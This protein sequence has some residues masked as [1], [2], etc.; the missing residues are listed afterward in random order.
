MNNVCLWS[1]IWLQFYSSF[2]YF[3]C[4]F[5]VYCILEQAE[6]VWSYFGNDF[7]LCYLTLFFTVSNKS[8]KLFDL[9]FKVF[10]TFFIRLMFRNAYCFCQQYFLQYEF[11]VKTRKKCK[12]NTVY[13]PYSM[14]QCD[15]M[16]ITY[17]ILI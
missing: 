15:F 1:F 9:L 4:L 8:F 10:H 16:I 14:L 12:I 6:K 5:A 13:E 2:V 11:Q 17:C 7:R 3:C